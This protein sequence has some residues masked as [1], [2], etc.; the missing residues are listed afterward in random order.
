MELTS[1]QNIT[2]YNEKSITFDV[3]GWGHTKVSINESMT[4]QDLYLFVGLDN[5][6]ICQ[7]I[8]RVD[9]LV[10]EACKDENVNF[11]YEKCDDKVVQVI[12]ILESI[13]ENDRNSDL[14]IENNELWKLTKNLFFM[15]LQELKLL[16]VSFL[17]TCIEISILSYSFVYYH[18]KSWILKHFVMIFGKTLN[19]Y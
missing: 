17:V 11:I 18:R 5:I 12:H 14:N 16:I 8:Y 6:D 9:N 10:L 7:V 4:A 2:L 19:S 3:P 13:I 1:S 15:A